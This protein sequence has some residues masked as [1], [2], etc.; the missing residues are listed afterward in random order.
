MYAHAVTAR[1]IH[2]NPRPPL[3]LF[4]SLSGQFTRALRNI[5][6]AHGIP[7]E[8]VTIRGVLQSGQWTGSALVIGSV[9]AHYKDKAVNI[10]D[11]PYGNGPRAPLATN[12]YTYPHTPVWA[13]FY[14]HTLSIVRASCKEATA[15]GVPVFFR[16]YSPTRFR[17]R[18]VQLLQ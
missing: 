9:F 16:E 4:D 10:L 5:L 12:P 11:V 15:R 18:L 17:T 3:T 14:E 13:T 7:P 6:E 2:L 8:K 1:S